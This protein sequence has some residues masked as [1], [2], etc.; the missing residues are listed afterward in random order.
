M[1]LLARLGQGCCWRRSLRVGGAPSAES[2]APPSSARACRWA[3]HVAAATRRGWS[4]SMRMARSCQQQAG[5]R[6]RLRRIIKS[7][8]TACG[9]TRVFAWV[10]AL[11]A[12]RCQHQHQQQAR[13]LHA[14][15]VSCSRHGSEQAIEC[16]RFRSTPADMRLQWTAAHSHCGNACAWP[17]T[18]MPRL[19]AGSRTAPR[20]RRCPPAQQRQP[21]PPPLQPQQQRS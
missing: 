5:Q 4:I 20:Q 15:I 11:A 18:W 2:A 17:G 21:H 14:A 10:E 1:R 16:F 7:G 6:Q 19:A 3:A 8:K 13:E 9:L 12:R